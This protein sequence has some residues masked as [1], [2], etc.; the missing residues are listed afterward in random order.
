MEPVT[1]PS[2]YLALV[3]DPAAKLKL[4]LMTYL[5]AVMW[6]YFDGVLSRR[7]LEIAW[8]EGVLLYLAAIQVGRS[9][10]LMLG[11]PFPTWTA[12]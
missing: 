8:F 7:T 2:A 1:G 5:L 9:I 3:D 10:R 12:P 11:E 6:S 4:T